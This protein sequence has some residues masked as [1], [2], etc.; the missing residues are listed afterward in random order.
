MAM[1]IY[2]LLWGHIQPMTAA[3]A[4]AG[5]SLLAKLKR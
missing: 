2:S 4:A 1:H 3:P 5:V